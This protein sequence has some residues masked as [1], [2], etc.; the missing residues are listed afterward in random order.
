[1]SRVEIK[2]FSSVHVQYMHDY[3]TKKMFMW[4]PHFTLIS[5]ILRDF[6]KK[7]D[8]LVRDRDSWQPSYQPERSKISVLGFHVKYSLEP[9]LVKKKNREY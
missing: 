2:F 7:R 4:V 1:M 8:S 3:V 5:F 6:V 9:W